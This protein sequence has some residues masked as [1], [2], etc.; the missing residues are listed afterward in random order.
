M[1][2]AQ[3]SSKNFCFQT[4]SPLTV[5]ECQSI[6]LLSLFRIAEYNT[7]TGTGTQETLPLCLNEE[8]FRISCR[9]INFE[10]FH[11]SK[12]NS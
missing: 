2:S 4:F 8:L 9:W 12:Q 11:S 5:A 7:E 6:L 3:I 1:K 10:T